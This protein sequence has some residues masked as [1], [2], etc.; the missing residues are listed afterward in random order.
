MI[1]PL[2][3]CLALIS[4]DTP[5][6]DISTANHLLTWADCL[7]RP[8]PPLLPLS[9]TGMLRRA[10]VTRARPGLTRLDRPAPHLHHHPRAQHR[11]RAALRHRMGHP[12]RALER[13]RCAAVSHITRHKQKSLSSWEHA[14]GAVIRPTSHH[15]SLLWVLTWELALPPV[16]LTAAAGGLLFEVL[17]RPKVVTGQAA[18]DLI[19]IR[20][21]RIESQRPWVSDMIRQWHAWVEVVSLAKHRLRSG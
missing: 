16:C 7:P 11:D 8:P 14:G 12:H 17:T 15:W 1:A 4:H 20:V 9:T 2:S 13:Q 6:L 18:I 19:R 5:P 3:Y 21:T 10:A